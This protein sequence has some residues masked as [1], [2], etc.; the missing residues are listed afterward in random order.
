MRL[1][2]DW[3]WQKKLLGLISEAEA[4]KGLPSLS[5]PL[6]AIRSTVSSKELASASNCQRCGWDIRK[7]RKTQLKGASTGFS[8]ELADGN[9]DTPEQVI[10]IFLQVLAET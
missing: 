6:P 4:Q 7:V 5:C 3:H 2:T 9:P 1:A 8:A 10:F